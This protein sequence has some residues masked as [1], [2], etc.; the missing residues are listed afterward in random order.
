[1]DVR[2][3]YPTRCG[4]CHYWDASAGQTDMLGNKVGTCA[5]NP[6]QVVVV[7]MPDVSKLAETDKRIVVSKREQPSDLP[8][9]QAP[10]GAFPIVRS[11]QWCGRFLEYHKESRPR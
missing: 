2:N 1:M 5:F 6:P 4:R 8:T 7:A 3:E 10:I 9:I 11:S